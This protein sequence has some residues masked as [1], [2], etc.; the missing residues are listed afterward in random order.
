MGVGRKI[1]CISF[2]IEFILFLSAIF[3]INNTYKHFF[4]KTLFL[5]ETPDLSEIEK[6]LKSLERK[7][8]STII[9]F[10]V[11]TLLLGIFLIKKTISP[12][13][14]IIKTIERIK[15]GDFSKTPIKTKDKPETLS[16]SLNEIIKKLQDEVEIDKTKEIEKRKI[17]FVSLTAHQLQAPLSDIK[18][19]LDMMIKGDFGKITKEQK[20][21]LEK[22]Y[23]INE[24]M[25]ALINELLN[26]VRF[27]ERGEEYKFSYEDLEEI[28]KKVL[29]GLKEVINQKKIKVEFKS[30]TIPKIKL[31]RE[32][33]SFVVQTLIENAIFYNIPQGMVEIS[34]KNDPLSKKIIF[35]VKDTG[36]GISNEDKKKVFNIPF[37][38]ELAAKKEMV[39]SGLGL[40]WA[41]D[42]I[43][44]HKGEIWFESE[45]GKG[46]T[47]YFSL[48]VEGVGN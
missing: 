38:G 28:T 48:P 42:I 3:L 8:I 6:G 18:W 31:D 17:Q 21:I 43:L 33:I 10:F 12:F 4:E 32:K 16:S 7:T 34:L 15:E 39:G 22:T 24:R 11:F 37:R 19:G 27:E 13:N 20:E 45:E 29:E 41:K 14:K 40:F 47:F 36:I 26:I 23:Q 35:S 46:S 1:I 25:I 44:K 2:V 30:E 5:K 9:F